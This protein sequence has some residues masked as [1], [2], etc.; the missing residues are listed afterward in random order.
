[1]TTPSDQR[2]RQTVSISLP[3]DLRRW[4][5]ERAASERRTVSAYVRIL[6]ERE[7]EGTK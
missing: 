1:M 5:S 6:I 3:P 4:L 7:L 2:D